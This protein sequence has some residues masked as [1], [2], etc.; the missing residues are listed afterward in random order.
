MR[1]KLRSTRQRLLSMA[2]RSAIAGGIFVALLSG[3]VARQTISYHQDVYPIL[4]ANCLACHRPP[5]GEGYL[6]THLN[7]ESYR[8]L[9]QGTLYGPVIIPGDSRKSILNM[10]VEGRAD[11]SLRMPHHRDEPLTAKEIGI[12]QLW[13][14]QGARDN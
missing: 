6:K 10:L 9:M 2:Y 8:S 13:V 14:D 1:R 11:A 3:C 5:D 7:M 4:E 12:L